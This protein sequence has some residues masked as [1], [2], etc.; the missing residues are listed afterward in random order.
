MILL[1]SHQPLHPGTQ[2]EVAQSRSEVNDERAEHHPEFR[3]WQVPF[4]LDQVNEAVLSGQS[5]PLAAEQNTKAQKGLEEIEPA[6]VM[7]AALKEKKRNGED[8]ERAER[9]DPVALFLWTR[10]D[11]VQ[12]LQ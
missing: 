9:Y 7:M 4:V 11:K 6:H 10:D 8:Y 2:P 1:A 3:Y 12:Q 5:K